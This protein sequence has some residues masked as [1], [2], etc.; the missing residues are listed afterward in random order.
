M[1]TDPSTSTPSEGAMEVAARAHRATNYGMLNSDASIK[2]IAVA[3]D[4]HT[5][6][7][8]NA[9]SGAWKLVG[10][11]ETEIAALR[12]E[13]A[14]MK[15]TNR[16]IHNSCVDAANSYPGIH[17]ES[18]SPTEAIAWYEEQLARK[19]AVIAAADEANVILTKRLAAALESRKAWKKMH[20]AQDNWHHV[21]PE[22]IA[23]D[24]ALLALG[25]EL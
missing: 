24:A 10:V 23:A 20:H 9:A 18:F 11:K 7:L 5:N 15:S 25:V 14:A 1:T 13:L 6:E 8:R 21:H 3:L 4:D 2:V 17:G 12:A 22:A 19:D 16:R